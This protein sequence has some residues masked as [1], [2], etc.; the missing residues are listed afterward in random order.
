MIAP[1]MISTVGVRGASGRGRVC[2]P[3]LTK[4]ADYALWT[5][6]NAWFSSG[7]RQTLPSI[8]FDLVGRSGTKLGEE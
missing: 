2:E 3:A 5:G 1:L 4:S 6:V 8:S 7:N